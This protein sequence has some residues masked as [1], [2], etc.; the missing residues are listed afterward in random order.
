[1]GQ[2]WA[3]DILGGFTY[4]LN[5]SKF[6]RHAVQPT[7]KWRQFA[8]AKDASQQGK[9]RGDLF[10]W[11]NYGDLQTQGGPIPENL[12]IPKTQANIGQSS[13]QIT[14]YGNSTDYTGKLDDLSEH[15]IK[16][17]INKQL[18]HDAKKAL[19]LA[20]FAQ[21]DSTPLVI[22]PTGGTSL[23]DITLATNGTPVDT[24]DAPLTLEHIKAISDMMKERNVPTYEDTDDYYNISHPSTLRPVKSELEQLFKYTETGLGQIK[25]GEQGR[26][27]GIRFV[28]QT[29]VPKEVWV[30][31]KS[32]FSF[33]F[34]DDTVNEAIVVS[35][36]MRGKIPGDYGRDKGLA[37]YFMGGYGLVHADPVQARIFKWASAA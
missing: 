9:N 27:E 21:F 30:N 16:V 34:G 5:L 24:N 25:N 3:T 36:Q 2:V 31:G 22:T 33:F 35:E 8:V 14:E 15:P 28:E 1:M 37:W 23:T 18:K 10:H 32:N 19:D 11:N 6:L 4:A 26:Y 20:T 17:I 7:I 13:L 12:P 29:H